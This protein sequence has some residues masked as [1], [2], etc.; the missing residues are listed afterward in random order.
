MQDILCDAADLILNILMVVEKGDF[1]PSRSISLRIDSPKLHALALEEFETDYFD[2]YLPRDMN[3]IASSKAKYMDRDGAVFTASLEVILHKIYIRDY[4]ID[5]NYFV[6][7]LS[8]IMEWKH[9]EKVFALSDIINA[10]RSPDIIRDQTSRQHGEYPERH[11]EK[12]YVYY[13]SPSYYTKPRRSRRYGERRHKA[14][15]MTPPPECSE[16]CT[17]FYPITP[18][19]SPE[20]SEICA[21]FYPITPPLSPESLKGWLPQ[22][23]SPISP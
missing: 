23:Y 14:R 17:T 10:S 2:L 19:L 13:K 3:G 7:D 5:E 1:N 15:M 16:I 12:R 8:N 6:V 22:G 11:R 9:A 20:C 21:T 18:P 4:T